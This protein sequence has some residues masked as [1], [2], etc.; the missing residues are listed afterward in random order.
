MTEAQGTPLYQI[1][2][3]YIDDSA[4]I[5]VGIVRDQLTVNVGEVA[6]VGSPDLMRRAAAEIITACLYHDM[7]WAEGDVR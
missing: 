4:T 5:A 3:A 2:R 6:L 7:K 1:Q